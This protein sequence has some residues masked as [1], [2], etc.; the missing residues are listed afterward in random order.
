M[1][2]T[3]MLT[4]LLFSICFVIL[5]ITS[6]AAS[7]AVNSTIDDVDAVP[8]NGV[9]ATAG[10]LCTLRAAIQEANA[11]SGPDVVKLKTGLYMLTSGGASENDCATG[12][13]DITNDLTII[14]TGV[15]KTFINGGK[16]DRVFHIIGAISVTMTDVAIQNGLATDDGYGDVNNVN[17]G[18]ILNESASTLTLKGITLSNN[19]ASGGANSSGGGIHNSGTLTITKS[20]LSNS[21]ISNNA[22]SGGSNA[23]YGGAIYNNAGTLKIKAT[24]I[25]NNIVSGPNLGFGGAIMNNGNATIEIRQSTI[26]N[27]TVSAQGGYS[28]GGGIF[29]NG[30]LTIIQSTISNNTAQGGVHGDGGGIF[31]GQA[32]GSLTI[33][34]SIISSNVARGAFAS[35]G[36]IATYWGDVVIT[37]STLSNNAASAVSGNPG[38]GGGI[39]LGEYTTVTVQ[40]A[41]KIVRNFSSDEGGG[42]CYGGAGTGTVSGDRGCKEHPR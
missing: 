26:S 27:N 12:D 37:G 38:R 31:N 2:F 3:R 9:C 16:L 21:T 8:G 1:N 34:K 11:L 10:D 19:A 39:F 18:G 17:G 40:G 20:L 42:I 14:G 7:F 30:T 13:I 35:G 15:K 33:T 4:L 41:S 25:F 22:A 32:P 23:I 24:S 6:E 28:E 29:S 36:G 5:P